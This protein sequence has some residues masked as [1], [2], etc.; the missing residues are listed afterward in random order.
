MGNFNPDNLKP[1]FIKPFLKLVM[2]TA[3]ET[4]EVTF[5]V[6]ESIRKHI[7]QLKPLRPKRSLICI[8][9]F[10]AK[11]LIK[12]TFA[13]KIGDSQP[14]FIQKSSKEIPS[15]DPHDVIEI[16]SDVDTHFWFDIA[17]YLTKNETCSAQLKSRVEG[18][19]DN[20]FLVSLW[21]GLGSALLPVLISQF[22]ASNAN[23]AALAVLPSKA[24][25]SDAH[26][27]AFASLG[28]CASNNAAAVVL[29]D[30]DCVE[31]F[32]GVDRDGSRMR[33][34]VII[35]YVLGM[36]LEKEAFTQ[37]LSELS[38]SFNVK[39]YTMLAVTGA[40]LKIYGSFKNILNAASLN[41][42]LTFDLASTSVLHILVRAPLR[43]KEKLSKGKIELAT[44]KWS[45]KM[46]KIKSIYVSEPI[47]VDEESDRVDT[48]VFAGGFELTQLTA[49]FQKKA[50]EVKNET[51][52]KGLI[53]DE[54]WEA[55]VKGLAANQ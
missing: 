51:I 54:E 18:L 4:T 41:P 23:S 48:V 14:I 9:E 3:V 36:M 15:A 50:A 21:E 25:P 40:S 13:K 37:E 1:Y 24:Q 5:D 12:E 26:F 22:N 2:E 32:V 42:F 27:N 30:R 45:R 20:I 52:K 16:G 38:R 35:D 53:K 8:G 55:I 46:P 17:S 11:I 10:P 49:F 43:L 39:L 6:I 33:G 29:L 34:N 28:M 7:A 19:H 31:D 44:A 47:Y